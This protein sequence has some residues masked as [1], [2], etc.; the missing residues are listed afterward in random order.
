MQEKKREVS[1]RQFE[2]LTYYANVPGS[3]WPAGARLLDIDALVR[4]GWLDRAARTADTCSVTEEGVEAILD[5]WTTELG[6]AGSRERLRHDILN[7]CVPGSFG[8]A[9]GY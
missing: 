1:R 9:K 5:F 6:R 4:R 2:L 3:E 8:A 7:R